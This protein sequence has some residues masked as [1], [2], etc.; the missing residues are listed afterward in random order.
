MSGSARPRNA[1]LTLRLCA[2]LAT[3][4]LLVSSVVTRVGAEAAR[5]RQIAELHGRQESLC[6]ALGVRAASLLERSDALRLTVLASSAADLAGARI[7]ILDREGVVQVDTGQAELGHLLPLA[8][9][10][11]LAS[12]PLGTDRFEVL[13][14]SL[15]SDGFAGEVRVRYSTA[16]VPPAGFPWSLFGLVFLCS[17]TLVTLAGWMAH[18]W[19]Q[20]LR[21]IAAQAR[22]IARGE[23]PGSGSRG[24]EAGAVA[25]VRDALFELSRV[26]VESAR[27]A[28]DGYLRLAR[29][30]V[31]ALELR[32]HVPVGHPERVRRHAEALAE[33][34]GIDVGVRQTIAEAA[35]VLDLGKAG[36]RPSAFKRDGR[37]GEL[38]LASL[39]E[40]P[41]R[42]A[43]LLGALPEL[44]DVA[45]AVRHHRERWDGSGNPD[46]LR[47]ERIPVASRV[48][49]I[50][51]TYDE[52]LT[53][54]GQRPSLSWPAA[55]DAMREQC[56]AIF[57]PRLVQAFE[58][59]VRADPPRQ[60][61]AAVVTVP[62]AAAVGRGSLAERDAAGLEDELEA[63]DSPLEVLWDDEP[64]RED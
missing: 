58:E 44:A 46:G 38:E 63:A 61:V 52:L 51:S 24:F 9:S 22:Q 54:D 30:V 56:G 13:A 7:L 49:A 48:L 33:A 45:V 53:G 41:V 8:T 23:L 35:L 50:A 60:R 34:V 2:V 26:G 28:R 62:L 36:V 25:E 6:A 10:D 29:E 4:A 17:A 14:P 31:H 16:G 57:D 39:R 15:G 37:I 19:M 27:V 43:S 47:G 1:S 20:R 40:H 12:R 59:S 55:L 42:G 64:K 18:S 11:G 32:G 3:G 5:E 21:S